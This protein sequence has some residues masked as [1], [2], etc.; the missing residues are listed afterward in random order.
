M[1]QQ[2]MHALIGNFSTP[3]MN[4]DRDC[5]REPKPISSV[6]LEYS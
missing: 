3:P 6:F 5:E 2:S 1:I 4:R